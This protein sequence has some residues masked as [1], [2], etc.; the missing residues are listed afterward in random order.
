MGFEGYLFTNLVGDFLFA[1]HQFHFWK[2]LNAFVYFVMLNTTCLFR[3]WAKD[4]YDC[5]A[6]AK[7][8]CIWIQSK[9]INPGEWKLSSYLSF[10]RYYSH[11]FFFAEG[12][13][14]HHKEYM[15]WIVLHIV[16]K[17]KK[18]RAFSKSNHMQSRAESARRA[19]RRVGPGH[20]K[21]GSS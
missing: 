19:A 12:P 18:S 17:Y 16:F 7:N 10:G 11:P 21:E 2:D 20:A 9:L 1:R 6:Y 8:S 13:E 5:T 14:F 15:W 3:H 4:F